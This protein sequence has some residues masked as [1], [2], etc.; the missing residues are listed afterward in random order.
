[1]K[2]KSLS[3]RGKERFSYSAEKINQKIDSYGGA[4]VHMVGVANDIARITKAVEEIY[5]DRV[6]YL[7]Y[8]TS[9]APF[10]GWT[11][12][13]HGKQMDEQWFFTKS[14]TDKFIELYALLLAARG[15]RMEEDK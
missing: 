13:T 8:W 2:E 15:L 6:F 11:R 4:T 9:D 12:E 14:I 10:L 7:N 1:M 5:A 3:V